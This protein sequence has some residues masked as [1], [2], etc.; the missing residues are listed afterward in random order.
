MLPEQSMGYEYLWT[1]Y[2]SWDQKPARN[3]ATWPSKKGFQELGLRMV[4][5][6]KWM[7]A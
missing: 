3:Y 4:T 1:T 7:S 2:D 5:E 6:K